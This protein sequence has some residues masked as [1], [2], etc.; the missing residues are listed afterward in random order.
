[1]AKNYSVRDGDFESVIERIVVKAI[2]FLSVYAK[3]TFFGAH[4]K[5]AETKLAVE[6]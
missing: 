4:F 1:M 5:N 2:V 6:K 3:Q